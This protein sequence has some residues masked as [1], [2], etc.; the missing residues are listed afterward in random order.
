MTATDGARLTF[1][2]RLLQ[3]LPA[4]VMFFSC[5]TQSRAAAEPPAT[6]AAFVPAAAAAPITI[7]QIRGGVYL[8]NGKGGNSVVYVTDEGVVLVD[9]KN[10]GDAIVDEILTVIRTV[11]D[12]PVKYVIN[13]HYHPDHIGNNGRFLELGAQ[14]ISQAKTRDYTLGPELQSRKEYDLDGK[15]VRDV[16]WSPAIAKGEWTP[17][18]APLT[19]TDEI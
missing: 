12:K 3:A 13:T 1:R 16:P 2:T 15:F 18:G 8:L 5:P 6:P 10:H 17:V 7:R 9:D 11:T 19:F 14:V 4:I